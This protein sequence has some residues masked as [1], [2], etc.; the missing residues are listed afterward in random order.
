MSDDL[1]NRGPAD[2]DRI[3]IHE[4]WEVTYWCK[5]FGC[6]EQQ[7]VAAVKAVGVMASD[8][9]RHLANP[10]PVLRPPGR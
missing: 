6:T 7:L 9:K 10:R 8:V 3:N 5:H 1:T 2:R 4:R